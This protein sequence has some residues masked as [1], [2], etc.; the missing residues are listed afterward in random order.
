MDE[1][2]ISKDVSKRYYSTRTY[3]DEKRISKDLS[4][5]YY[6]PRTYMDEIRIRVAKQDSSFYTQEWRT[7]TSILYGV[8]G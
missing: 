4:I 5:C 7:N 3:M 1:K 6:S 2:Q 8:A